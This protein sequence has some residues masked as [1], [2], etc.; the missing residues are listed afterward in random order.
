MLITWLRGL[1]QLRHPE[2]VR[3]LGE[4]RQE[5]LLLQRIRQRYP[6]AKIADGVIIT[7]HHGDDCLSLGRGSAV[8]TGTV[9][10]FVDEKN[11]FGRLILGDKSWVGQYNNL[12]ACGNGDIVVGN[13][14]LISQFCTLVGSNHAI[15]CGRPVSA[16]GP[17]H[18]RLGVV[19]GNDVWL[20]AGV[21][22]MPGVAIA[23]GAVI[24]AN[25]VVTKSVPRNEIWAGSP[26]RRIGE[27]R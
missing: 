9:L 21:T 8:E 25:T 13:E 15:R 26:A 4:R 3:F 23:D 20:G 11:G 5:L 16:Q 10:A 18:L 22:V 19:L 12:R 14:C 24:G 1:A 7:G 17:D 6:D 2:V 27:R